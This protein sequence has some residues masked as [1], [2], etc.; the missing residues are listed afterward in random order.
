[1][2]KF[3]NTYGIAAALAALALLVGGMW[4]AASPMRPGS[5]DLPPQVVVQ[6]IP[7][8]ESFWSPSTWGTTQ[9]AGM[10]AAAATEGANQALNRSVAYTDIGR[11]ADA[12][13]TSTAIANTFI[14]LAVIAV[15]GIL[16]IGGTINGAAKVARM[17][18]QQVDRRDETRPMSSA[19]ATAKATTPAASLATLPVK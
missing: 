16:A 2:M 10:A 3:L 7:T 8:D 6:P 19:P 12:A 18:Q 17:Q 9:A 14:V 13:A 15:G 4:V 5:V 11:K 1:M